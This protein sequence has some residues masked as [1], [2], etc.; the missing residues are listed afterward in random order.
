LSRPERRRRPHKVR[1]VLIKH[2]TCR[3]PRSTPA[4]HSTRTTSWTWTAPPSRAWSAPRARRRRRV[5][6][7]LSSPRSATPSGRR[8]SSPRRPTCPRARLLPRSSRRR[9]SAAQ[10]TRSPRRRRLLSADARTRRREKASRPREEARATRGELARPVRLH[11]LGAGHLAV[12]H[13][14]G[15]PRH[16]AQGRAR[17]RRS[18]RRRTRGAAGLG[19]GRAVL[20]RAARRTRAGPRRRQRLLHGL[21]RRRQVV[22]P[23]GDHAPP[24]A[25]PAPVPGDGDDRHRRPPD[26]RHHGPL[27]GRRRPRQGHGVGAVRQDHELAR[28][29][30][31]VAQHAG[32][33]HRRGLDEPGRPV[34]QAARAR[35]ARAQEQQAVRRH[36][37][38]SVG[39]LLPASSCTR[40]KAR[41][42]VY[43]LRCV[44]SRSRASSDP[45]DFILFSGHHIIK[46]LALHDA[47]LPY[48]ERA[49]PVPQA[50]I[51]RCV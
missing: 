3:R 49:K 24:R 13:G 2:R 31:D 26:Q 9:R 12:R 8:L 4:L 45:S 46:K 40:A 16:Q 47:C 11:D 1:A 6:L 29:G 30:E 22:P 5:R 36:P 51:Y 39:R 17:P 35:Q 28:E 42:A 21:G 48:E 14:Q 34:H 44:P 18:R 41:L 10:R 20:R 15:R 32:P 19:A 25:S 27:V 23:A 37:A 7:D 38:H 43:A 50:D 33:R